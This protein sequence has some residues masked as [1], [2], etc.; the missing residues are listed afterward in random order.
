MKEY[1]KIAAVAIAA[2]AIAKWVLPKVGVN[3]L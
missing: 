2:V 1:A 3:V